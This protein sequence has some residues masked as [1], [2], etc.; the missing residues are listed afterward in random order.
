MDPTM[1]PTM[2]MNGT[3]MMMQM[4]FYASGKAT[5]VPTDLCCRSLPGSNAHPASLVSRQ[6]SNH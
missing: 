1:D 5:P 2:M 4:T 3:T 6:T